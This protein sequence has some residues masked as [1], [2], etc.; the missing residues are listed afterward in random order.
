MHGMCHSYERP[1]QI[2]VFPGE[3]GG[4]VLESGIWRVDP[5]RG[6]LLVVGKE[7]GAVRRRG[8]TAGRIGGGA[9]ATLEARSIVKWQAR[10]RAT[11]PHWPSLHGQR[12]EHTPK[13]DQ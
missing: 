11:I 12:Q 2:C 8:A 5:R 7:P 10:G 13:Q 9:W 1:S 6:Q 3:E 4:W